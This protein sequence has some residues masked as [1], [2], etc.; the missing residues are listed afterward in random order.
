M[1]NKG[2]VSLATR[3]IIYE[4]TRMLQEADPMMLELLRAFRNVIN[5]KTNDA[6]RM[7]EYRRKKKAA[8][9]TPD[10]PHV[11]FDERVTNEAEELLAYARQVSKKTNE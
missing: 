4:M 11:T 7:Q 9:V 10:A 8:I 2:S 5:A 3:E 1:D 6:I